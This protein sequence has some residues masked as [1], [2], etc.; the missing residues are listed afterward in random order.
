MSTDSSGNGVVALTSAAL[1][2]ASYVCALPTDRRGEQLDD[3]PSRSR[4][5]LGLAAIEAAGDKRDVLVARQAQHKE[6]LG[7]VRLGYKGN[8]VRGVLFPP[9]VTEDSLAKLQSQF[10][11]R[12]GDVFVATYPKCGTTWMQNI[13]ALLKHGADESHDTTIPVDT[14]SE[15]PWVEPIFGSPGGP[16]LLDSLDSPRVF[17]TH[18]PHH[19]LPFVGGASA[20]HYF[21][22]RGL[23]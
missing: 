7:S 23:M 11:C 3:A 12:H 21:A 19:L 17:K 4:L 5:L 13:V 6:M 1:A 20:S 14:Q 2:C 9:F 22:A 10:H 18:A 15:T 8:M 16:E